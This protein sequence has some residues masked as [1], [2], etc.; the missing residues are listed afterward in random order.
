MSETKNKFTPRKL[1]D[2]IEPYEADYSDP[3]IKQ[4][5]EIK[6]YQKDENGKFLNTEDYPILKELEPINIQD[7]I[8]SFKDECDIYNILERVAKGETNLLNQKTPIFKSDA[9][10]SNIPNNINDQAEYFKNI[11]IK[12]AEILKEIEKLKAEKTTKNET[13]ETTNEMGEIKQ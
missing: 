4:F 6:P 5:I 1:W 3:Y 8:D 2:P 10:I 9:D 7:Y 11:E 13:A 12:Q